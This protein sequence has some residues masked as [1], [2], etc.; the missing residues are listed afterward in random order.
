MSVSPKRSRSEIDVI[1]L[2]LATVRILFSSLRDKRAKDAARI[3]T[4][5][6][7]ADHPSLE[8]EILLTEMIHYDMCSQIIEAMEKTML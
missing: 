6:L 5:E 3:E 1:R 2:K 7:S 4:G 8:Q